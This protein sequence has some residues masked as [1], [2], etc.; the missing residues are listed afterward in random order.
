MKHLVTAIV[1]GIGYAVFTIASI[2]A[3]PSMQSSGPVGAGMGLF[4]LYLIGTAFLFGLIAGLV[5]SMVFRSSTG[6]TNKI[7][8]TLV[9]I[10]LPFLVF[11]FN[12]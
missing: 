6:R 3:N 11:L 4:F 8:V 1:A 9:I 12:L 2:Y 10:Y 7:A 5:T